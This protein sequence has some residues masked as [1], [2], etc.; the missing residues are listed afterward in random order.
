MTT[1]NIFSEISK[2]RSALVMPE[3]SKK[4]SALV[5]RKQQLTRDYKAAV[6]EIDGEISQL[7]AAIN[8][9]N[10]ALAPH[11]CKTCGGS[12]EHTFIDAAGSRDSEPCPECHGT[13]IST[14]RGGK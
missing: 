11:L 14:Q 2:K 10:E 9:I 3:I 13:G 7:D 5:M 8:T 12:G 1:V 4:R 6:A